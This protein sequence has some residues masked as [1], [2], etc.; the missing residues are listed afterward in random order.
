M[1]FDSWLELGIIIITNYDD[2]YNN[3]NNY[4]DDNDERCERYNYLGEC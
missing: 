3:Y 4:D 2:N 1:F